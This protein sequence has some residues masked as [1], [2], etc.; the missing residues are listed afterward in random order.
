M[1]KSSDNSSDKK[2]AVDI[3]QVVKLASDR[4]AVERACRLI[5]S[6][7]AE[8]WLVSPDRSNAA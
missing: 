5:D 4:L 3:S 1:R 6:Y 8:K 7:I 2:N